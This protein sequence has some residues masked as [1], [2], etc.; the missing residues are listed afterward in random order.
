M[1]DR[2]AQAVAVAS[3]LLGDLD[4]QRLIDRRAPARWPTSPT[5][6]DLDH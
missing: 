5:A 2:R 3:R 6:R 1:K 4:L